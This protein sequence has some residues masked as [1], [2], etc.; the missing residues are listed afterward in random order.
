MGGIVMVILCIILGIIAVTL[1]M[2]CEHLIALEELIE[3]MK[4]WM[5]NEK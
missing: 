4:F 2:I 1:I 5:R 3:G